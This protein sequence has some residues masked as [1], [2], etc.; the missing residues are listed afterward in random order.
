M[1]IMTDNRASGLTLIRLSAPS[2]MKGEG[3]GAASSQSVL[4][5][6]WEKVPEG[7]MRGEP[8]ALAIGVPA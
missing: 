4:L 1:R 5:P 3:N 7:R 8:L 2:A 6:L